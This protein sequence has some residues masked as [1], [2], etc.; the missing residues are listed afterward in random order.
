M[1]HIGTLDSRW[2][3]LVWWP[4][5]AHSAPFRG[6]QCNAFDSFQPR[7]RAVGCFH[8]FILHFWQTK[9][10]GMK[11][12]PLVSCIAAAPH[13]A[14]HRWCPMAASCWRH[15]W[16]AVGR[17]A[18]I[19]VA[20][21]SHWK[22][23]RAAE[24]VDYGGGS[25]RWGWPGQRVRVALRPVSIESFYFVEEEGPGRFSQNNL[26]SEGGAREGLCAKMTAT[27]GW[28]MDGPD[29][30]CAY[31]HQLRMCIRYIA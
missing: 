29:Q 6:N 20:R 7:S 14:S 23:A 28:Q 19:S 2:L 27:F 18:W 22:V 8:L 13:V 10:N 3:L 24:A 4:R 11:M 26:G 12:F 25:V 17:G 15:P 21:N 5:F 30:E 31:V 1:A 9:W 16:S